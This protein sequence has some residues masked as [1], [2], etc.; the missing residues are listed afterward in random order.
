MVMTVYNHV[1]GVKKDHKKAAEYYMRAA[2]L[3]PPLA[4]VNG[5]KVAPREL[6]TEMQQ[7][8]LSMFHLGLIYSQGEDG[9]ERS[10]EEAFK[11]WRKASKYK[12]PQSIYNM[13]TEW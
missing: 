7:S 3:I 8:L 4:E 2:E 1:Q 12:H 6:T 5:K 10:A 11:W 9:M 13:G